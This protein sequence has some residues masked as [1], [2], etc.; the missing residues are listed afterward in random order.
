MKR[1]LLFLY[2]FLIFN[3]LHA[4]T[5]EGSL[6]DAATKEA[7]SG[8]M[9]YLNGTSIYST[10]DKE[11]F[12]RLVVE[13]QINTTLVIRHLSY[14]TIT[15]DNPYDHI[16]NV[17]YLIEKVN[18]LTEAQVVADRFSRSEKMAIFKE[19]FLGENRG[20]KSCVILN[21][22]EIVLK[23]DNDTKKL[24]GFANNP[25][26]IENKYL[27]YLIIFDLHNFTI[28]YASNTLSKSEI[29]NFSIS[30][31]CALIDQS[32][33]NRI[34]A[35]RRN[36][37]YRRSRQCF[38]RNFIAHTLKEAKF[39][40]YNHYKQIEI[41]QYFI[42]TDTLSHTVVRVRPG[43][44]INKVSNYLK[45]REIFGEVSISYN[46]R[47]DSKAI[48]LTDQFSVDRFGNIN[49]PG[50]VLFVGDMGQQRI[51]DMLPLDFLY[52]P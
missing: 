42:V 51:G 33:N 29:E 34:I 38:W 20:G 18:R 16:E 43:T 26:M 48:F 24:V 30:G 14:E 13:G 9:V 5:I 4:Q 50:N 27:A 2:I 45:N 11:G 22:E 15:V 39:R 40:M 12:F 21:E 36:E 6:Y 47:F 46:N 37:I 10:S 17:F 49:V 7:I 32:P 35:N 41:G 28:Q 52:T 44:N 25:I 8:A 19:Q 3:P 23:F 1:H 31:T